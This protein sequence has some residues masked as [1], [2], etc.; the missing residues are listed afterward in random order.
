[1]ECMFKVL[2]RR[3]VLSDESL[4]EIN[5]YLPGRSSA[6][7]SVRDRGEPVDP[8]SL[9]VEVRGVKNLYGSMHMSS[10]RAAPYI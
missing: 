1:M 4:L 5:E 7:Y 3:G 2:R 9:F 10:I 8:V 6:V